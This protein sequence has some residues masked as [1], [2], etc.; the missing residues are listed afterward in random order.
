MKGVRRANMLGC[1]FDKLSF[2][3]TVEC[4]RRAITSNLSVQIVPG[5]IDTICKSRRDASFARLLWSSDL[6]VADGKPIVWFASWLGEPIKGRVSGTDLVWSC[7]GVSAEL[8][9][10]IALLGGVGDTAM[11]AA[12][13]MRGR[14][15]GA[16]LHAI[17]TPYPLTPGD[18]S[19]LVAQIRALGCKIVLIALGA[20]RQEEG[21]QKYLPE[22][23]ANVGIGIGSA[24]DIISGDRPQAPGWMRNAGL[25]WLNRTVQEPRRLG[26]RYLIEDMRVFGFLAVEL[27]RRRLPRRIYE[28]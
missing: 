28:Q 13:K 22:T 7:A 1:P 26:K 14:F 16:L 5:S 20:P 2:D 18:S 19:K 24:F 23:G 15:P 27:L 3:E 6:V 17:D 10:P 21:V 9:C 8:A 11:R 4:I 12:R 25:E